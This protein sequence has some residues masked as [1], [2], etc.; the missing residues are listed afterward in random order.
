MPGALSGFADASSAG[1]EAVARLRLGAISVSSSSCSLLKPLKIASY[2]FGGG[3]DEKIL[4]ECAKR[5]SRASASQPLGGIRLAFRRLYSFSR[6]SNAGQQSSQTQH[7]MAERTATEIMYENL[8][9]TMMQRFRNDDHGG[10][11]RHHQ[12]RRDG[13]ADPHLRDREAAA[14]GSATGPLRVACR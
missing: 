10:A 1:E 7:A 14:A 4:A 11:D 8:H 6:W 13:R 2:Y 9:T 5:I 3:R 12:Q